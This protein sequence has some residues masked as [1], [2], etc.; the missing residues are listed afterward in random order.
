MKMVR[1]EKMSRMRRTRR[2]K[3]SPKEVLKRTL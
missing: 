1:N 2:V 3:K